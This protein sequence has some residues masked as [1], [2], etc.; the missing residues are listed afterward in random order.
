MPPGGFRLAIVNCWSLRTGLAMRERLKGLFTIVSL[1]G[2][3]PVGSLGEAG[4]GGRPSGH[5]PR[6]LTAGAALV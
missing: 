2:Q 1:N 6:A 5:R 3:A 4:A